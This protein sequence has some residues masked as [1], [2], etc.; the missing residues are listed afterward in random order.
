[1]N[2]HKINLLEIITFEEVKYLLSEFEEIRVEKLEGSDNGIQLI[3]DSKFT[4]KD[5]MT[6]IYKPTISSLLKDLKNIGWKE[7]SLSE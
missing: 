4:T 5:V 6:V 1:M 3:L 2:I 7:Y